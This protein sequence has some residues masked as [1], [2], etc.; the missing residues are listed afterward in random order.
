MP[1]SREWKR[2]KSELK[3][4][5]DNTSFKKQ[6][7]RKNKK[8]KKKL[9]KN[10]IMQ[11]ELNYLQLQNLRRK[12]LWLPLLKQLYKRPKLKLKKNR[13]REKKKRKNKD[14]IKKRKMLNVLHPKEQLQM[15]HLQKLKDSE[16]PN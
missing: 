14:S 9:S 13:L 5:I 11:K 3:K 2:L 6:L 4:L 8:L 16:R 15:K 12:R 7:N 10:Q 1:R